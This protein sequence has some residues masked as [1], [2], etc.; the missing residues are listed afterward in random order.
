MVEAGQ[1]PFYTGIAAATHHK[2]SF[3]Q[4]IRERRNTMRSIMNLGI[5]AC[6]MMLVV[7]T[8][9]VG[10][11][12]VSGIPVTVVNPDSKP[13]PV[14]I[15]SFGYQFVGFTTA[16]VNGGGVLIDN[17][18]HPGV[19]GMNAL[20]QKEFPNSR[21]CTAP[22]YV[23]TF[24][25]TSSS[26]SDYAW[27]MPGGVTSAF[28]YNSSNNPFTF[29]IEFTRGVTARDATGLDCNSWRLTQPDVGGM[30]VDLSSGGILYVPDSCAHFNHV[31]CCAP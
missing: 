14:S 19:F 31:T 13:V 9:A 26:L 10:G 23:K 7:P 27:I 2:A 12:L 28:A 11:G 22:E 5:F 8:T 4:N 24:S 25:G 1:V 18:I 30:V 29:V 17:S 16:T 21:I 15:Q 6:V 3:Y 20:C